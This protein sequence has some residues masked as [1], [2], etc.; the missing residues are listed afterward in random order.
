MRPLAIQ[1]RQVTR[2]RMGS[3]LTEQIKD[4][5]SRPFLVFKV[6]LVGLSQL[7]QDLYKSRNLMVQS[8]CRK[9]FG[10]LACHPGNESRVLGL[11]NEKL[12]V[13]LESGNLELMMV[14]GC[15]S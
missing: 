11:G 12:A 15:F 5:T 3:V 14:F 9:L 6:L 13:R 7:A 8:I 1:K 4:L 10:Q 2:A